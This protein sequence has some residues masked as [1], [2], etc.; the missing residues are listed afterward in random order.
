MAPALAPALIGQEAAACALLGL[1]LGSVRAA[2]PV[3]GRAAILPDMALVGAVLLGLQSYAAALSAG[4]VLRWYMPGS[5]FPAAD[6]FCAHAAVPAGG[7]A[8]PAGPA[9][10]AAAGSSPQKPGGAG[11]SAPRAKKKRKKTEKELA[12]HTAVVV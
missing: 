1:V 8:A 12:K 7:G 6:E 2:F 9:G 4:G 11:R 3:R 10:I 5:A